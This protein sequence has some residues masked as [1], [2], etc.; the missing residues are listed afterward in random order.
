M[1]RHLPI[2][3]T[4]A[5][6]SRPT[7]QGVRE[8]FC[9]FAS[10]CRS[11]SKNRGQPVV[12]RPSDLGSPRTEDCVPVVLHAHHGPASLT[13]GVERGVGRLGVGVLAFGV[14]VVDHQLQRPIF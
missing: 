9:N 2:P 11:S 10:W 7:P 3:T 1:I 4:T 8:N 6:W 13:G 12:T 14:I 5:P